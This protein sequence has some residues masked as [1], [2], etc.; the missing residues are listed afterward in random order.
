MQ[1]VTGQS[2]PSAAKWLVA[3]GLSG[4]ASV[5]QADLDAWAGVP[6]VALDTHSLFLTLPMV[7]T[8]T[9]TGVEIRVYSNKQGV[10]SCA[11]GGAVASGTL[12]LA[13]F[14]SYRSCTS[15]LVGCDGVF[16]VRDGTVIEAKPVGQCYTN[17][18]T[19]PEKGYERFVK[20]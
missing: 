14:N 20:Q 15:R 11:G 5:H 9:D 17:A 3:I 16:Y 7:K 10:S 6:V 19:R 18:S 4:C 13:S 8:F 2:R 1:A 12:P